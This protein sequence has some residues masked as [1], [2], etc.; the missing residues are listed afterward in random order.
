MR[1]SWSSNGRGVAAE[2]NEEESLAAAENRNRSVNNGRFLVTEIA[3]FGF[4]FWEEEVA[5]GLGFKLAMDSSREEIRV[6]S[7]LIR[8]SWRSIREGSIWASVSG[9]VFGYW[10]WGDVLS[11]FR[12]SDWESREGRSRRRKKRGKREMKL[13]VAMRSG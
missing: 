11:G 12:V 4:A 2:G 9:V 5:W 8:A 10:V 1:L 3:G 7:R 6:S 13:A